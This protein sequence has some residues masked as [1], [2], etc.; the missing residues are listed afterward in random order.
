MPEPV[1]I[2]RVE[3]VKAQTPITAPSPIVATVPTSSVPAV[4]AKVAVNIKA[5]LINF[6][7][8]VAP[9]PVKLPTPPVIVVSS[10]VKVIPPP[11]FPPPVVTQSSPQL[12]SKPL[13]PLVAPIILSHVQP[14]APAAPVAPAPIEVNRPTLVHA[15]APVLSSHPLP[16]IVQPPPA[17]LHIL[18]PSAAAQMQKASESIPVMVAPSPVT[19]LPSLTVN[20]PPVLPELTEHAAPAAQ[21]SDALRSDLL[22]NAARMLPEVTDVDRLRTPY[23]PKNPVRNHPPYFPSVSDNIELN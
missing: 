15:V 10:P 21:R 9:A 5:P 6:A 8:V 4:V 13:L 14:T 11:A 17:L 19:A 23:V 18:L 16:G 20:A 7:A 22:D 2:K 3:S 12:K 1:I